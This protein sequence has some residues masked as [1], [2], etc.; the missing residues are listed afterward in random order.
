[1]SLSWIS[2]LLNLDPTDIL[3]Q[4]I[5]FG[6]DCLVH[7]GLFNTIHGV[8]SLDTSRP[9]TFSTPVVTTKMFLD[10]VRCYLQGGGGAAIALVEN[11]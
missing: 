11:H 7:C 6:E 4:L 1:M 9:P 10:I 5:L 3:G 8:S 2:G